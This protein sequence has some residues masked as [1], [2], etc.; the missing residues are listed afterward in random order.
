MQIQA[1]KTRHN[2]MSA[3]MVTVNTWGVLGLVSRWAACAVH[4]CRGGTSEQ[5]ADT[6]L[7]LSLSGS[8]TCV[9]HTFGLDRM[10]LPKI[11]SES[12]GLQRDARSDS[13]HILVSS[14][15]HFYAVETLASGYTLRQPTSVISSNHLL[16]WMFA[17]SN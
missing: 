13:N 3:G 14:G 5:Q 1:D 16:R 7:T 12:V 2:T 9:V 6:H 11:P 8:R 4:L 10:I 17:V 15:R